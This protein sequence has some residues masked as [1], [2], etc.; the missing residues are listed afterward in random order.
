[1]TLYFYILREYLKY[2]LG[3]LILCL[4]LFVLFDFI[5]K[6][7]R[8]FPTYNPTTSQIFKLYYY[9]LPSQFIQALP[10]ASLLAAVASM[11]M[12]AR[13]NE[14]TAM[15]AIGMGPWMVAIPL[16]VGGL[17]LSVVGLVLSETVMPPFSAKMRYLKEV[18]IEGEEANAPGET[19]GWIKTAD[20]LVNFQDFDP[21]N[22]RLRNIKLMK[23]S[24]MF[25]PKSMILAD[26]ADFD[27]ETKVWRLH[28]TRS[29]K[30]NSKLD[31]I[32]NV[33]GTPYSFMIPIDPARFKKERRRPNE[34]SLNELKD[35]VL[36]RR[37]AGFSTLEYAVEYQFKIAYIFAALVVVM[38]G[39]KFVYLSER[40]GDTVKG[41]LWAFASGGAYWVMIV[42]TRTF[43]SR[44]TMD[45]LLAAWT[46]NLGVLLISYLNVR[47]DQ[48][49]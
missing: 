21:L 47:R 48:K 26:Y 13:G 29:I 28:G 10:I 4:F 7:T 40:T 3:T 46:P 39:L 32:E 25:T 22:A 12:L 18:L 45:P 20:F 35:S 16:L 23:L 11:A 17:L 44:G 41:V 5:H 24:Q 19:T 37:D 33:V 43:A 6:T 14:L 2:A 1:M 15:R 49:G 9:M 36:K 38:A 27:S 42:I 31:I 30:F 34:F 8:Y